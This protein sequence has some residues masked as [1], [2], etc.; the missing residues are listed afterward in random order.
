MICVKDKITWYIKGINFC[1]AERT[2]WSS[3]SP[4]LLILLLLLYPLSSNP[5]YVLL[6]CVLWVW[7]LPK[8][9]YVNSS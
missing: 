7:V 9:D 4:R 2:M 5:F 1:V 8:R 6:M 3:Y